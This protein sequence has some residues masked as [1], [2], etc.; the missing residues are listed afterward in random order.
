MRPGWRASRK[1]YC[2]APFAGPEQVLRYLSRYTHR[3]ALTTARLH[4]AGRTI[5]LAARTGG[6]RCGFTRASSSG[7]S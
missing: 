4:S 1:G 5:A 2:K 3:V 6:R 7:A